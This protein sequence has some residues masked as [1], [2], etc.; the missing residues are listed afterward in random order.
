MVRNRREPLGEADR[1]YAL[2]REM[3]QAYYHPGMVRIKV[4]E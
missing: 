3:L 4:H 1:Y 2:L